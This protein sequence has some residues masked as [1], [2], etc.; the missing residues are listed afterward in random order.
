MKAYQLDIFYDYRPVVVSRDVVQEALRLLTHSIKH[1]P[2]TLTSSQAVRDYCR[3][4]L[5]TREHEVFGVLFLDSQHRLIEY[6]ELFRGT[7]D[8]CAIYVREV[9]KETL[10]LNAAAVIFTHNHP[11]G[12]CDPSDADIGITKKLREALALFDVRVLDHIIVSTEEVVS[13][14]DR[15]L[16]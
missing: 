1:K 10:R 6:R 8:G 5:A 14:A 13:F 4:H 9:A 2:F 7:I 11:S 16:I 15:G 3:L 12:V